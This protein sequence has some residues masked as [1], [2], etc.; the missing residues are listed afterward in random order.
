MTTKWIARRNRSRM[1]ATVSCRPWCEGPQR[2]DQFLHT[3]NSPPTGV[4]YSEFNPSRENTVHFLQIWIVP[5]FTGTS[6]G[7]QQK[8]FGPSEKRGKLRL[9]VS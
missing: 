6:A 4:R 2:A 1:D 5:K 9:R 8:F 3:T 7:Y